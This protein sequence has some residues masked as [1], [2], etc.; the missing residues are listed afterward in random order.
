MDRGRAERCLGLGLREPGT[1][2]ALIDPPFFAEW[3][4]L[5]GGDASGRRFPARLF[6]ACSSCVVH[7]KAP[8]EHSSVCSASTPYPAGHSQESDAHH[9]HG[10]WFG[11]GS[12]HH[13]RIVIDK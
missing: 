11:H 13:E 6:L 5:M 1:L 2:N 9:D 3:I 12:R 7:S 10:R 8:C 4:C